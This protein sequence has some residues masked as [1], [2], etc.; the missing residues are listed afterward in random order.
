MKEFHGIVRNGKFLLP[1]SQK[2]Q[3]ESFLKSLKDDTKVIET[4]RKEGKSKSWEQVKCHWGLVIS[5][6][7]SSF[8]D[9]G[10]DTSILLNLANP[11]GVEVSQGLLQEYLYA[12]CP[13]YNET[14][15]RVT[16][17]KMT[18]VEASK[19]FDDVRNYTASQWSIFIPEPRKDLKENGHRTENQG[20]E[21]LSQ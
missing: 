3:K 16:L 18:T 5:T 8:S 2:A 11:T 12:A 21:S 15:E 9:N 4:L 10:W 7:L 17:S 1:L 19:F 13:I 14:G 6:I 20:N